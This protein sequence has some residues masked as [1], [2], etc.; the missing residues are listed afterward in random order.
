MLLY[1]DKTDHDLPIKNIYMSTFLF[2][3]STINL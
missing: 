1:K 2:E 3:E